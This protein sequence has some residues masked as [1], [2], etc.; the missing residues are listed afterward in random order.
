MTVPSGSTGA[1]LAPSPRVS[2]PTRQVPHA[3]AGQPRLPGP[4]VLPLA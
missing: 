2:L 4:S 3:L 1:T